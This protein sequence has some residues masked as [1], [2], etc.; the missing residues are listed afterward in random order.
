MRARIQ[1]LRDTITVTGSS[2]TVRSTAA[3]SAALIS[4]RRSSPNF[5][6]SSF[7]SLMT[8]FFSSFSSS[9]MPFSSLRSASSAFRSS[10]SL[11]P[12]SLVS[13]PRRRLTMSCD[14][15]LGELVLLLQ[16]QLCLGLVFAA[17]I[18]LMISSIF[19]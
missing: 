2:T 3:R 8:S 15:P 17:R 11:M 13:W 18:S 5:F 14:L 6:A 7:S 1:P 9:R 19:T 4:V 16:I 12:S 10:F